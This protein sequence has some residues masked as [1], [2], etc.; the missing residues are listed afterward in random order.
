MYQTGVMAG[1]MGPVTLRT[2]P[3]QC[4]LNAIELIWAQVKG[5]VAKA[6]TSMK[7]KDVMA[8]TKQAMADITREQWAKVVQHTVGVERNYWKSDGLLE[9]I[10]PI[11]IHLICDDSSDSESDDDKEE[12]N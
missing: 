11:I 1:E 9:N 7:M 2:P 6:N 10:D 8:L 12:E 5:A 4:E 3:R